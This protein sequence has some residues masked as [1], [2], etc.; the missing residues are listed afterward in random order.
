[1]LVMFGYRDI[2]STSVS[3]VGALWPN[4]IYQLVELAIAKTLAVVRCQ[5]DVT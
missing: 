5:E 1:M 4:D 3:L 2:F